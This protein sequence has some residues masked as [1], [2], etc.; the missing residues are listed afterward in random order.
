MENVLINSKGEYK[1]CDFG[2]A[3]TKVHFFNYKR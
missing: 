3:T 2:S 1:L